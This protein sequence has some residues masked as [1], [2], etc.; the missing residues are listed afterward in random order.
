M[1]EMIQLIELALRL[2]DSSY[3]ASFHSMGIWV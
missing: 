3:K 2:I 1:S